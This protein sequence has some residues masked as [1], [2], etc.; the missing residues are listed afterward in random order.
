[1]VDLSDSAVQDKR[2]QQNA[3]TGTSE[4]A[5]DSLAEIF[6][7]FWAKLMVHLQPAVTHYKPSTRDKADGKR[8][9][10]NPLQG[11][12]K[13]HAT[14]SRI[15]GLRAAGGTPQRHRPQRRRAARRR[16]LKKANKTPRTIPKGT[17]LDHD[18][19]Q[20]RGK[21]TPALKQLRG[22]RGNPPPR[23]HDS[24]LLRRNPGKSPKPGKKLTSGSHR[25]HGSEVL[26]PVQVR[27]RSS[28]T[29]RICKV[30]HPSEWCPQ[31]S[32]DHLSRHASKAS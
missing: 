11:T 28:T 19:S 14:D 21:R 1:M 23:C 27:S 9:L 3:I 31:R 5:R 18:C 6:D 12:T 10:E 29:Y 26:I 20:T 7:R 8:R 4:H 13:P 24:P 17:T 22:R 32:F 15:M 16:Q 30:T 2:Q 25:V